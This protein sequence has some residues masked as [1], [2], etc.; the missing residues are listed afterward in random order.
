MNAE[1]QS[2]LKIASQV[3]LKNDCYNIRYVKFVNTW[4]PLVYIHLSLN[5]AW[6]IFYLVSYTSK[7]EF[8]FVN[9]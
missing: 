9:D 8:M 4:G 3:W 2:Q 7:N 1:K 5:Q 6:I